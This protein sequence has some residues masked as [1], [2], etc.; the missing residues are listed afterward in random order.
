MFKKILVASAVV[1][2]AAVIGGGVYYSRS[3]AINQ[4]NKTPIVDTKNWKTY[5]SKYGFV[6]KYPGKWNLKED[7]YGLFLGMGHGKVS[8]D[9]YNG[10][11]SISFGYYSIED[12]GDKEIVGYVEQNN[13]S[14][15]AR[16]LAEKANVISKIE[17]TDVVE[18]IGGKAYLFYGDSQQNPEKK[19]ILAHVYSLKSKTFLIVQQELSV[20]IDIFESVIK[21]VSI[22]K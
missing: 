10:Q 16:K 6:I 14:T 22:I 21:K 4:K 2:V 8:F 12:S 18:I 13:I 17:I 1:A 9:I 3:I 5:V 20:N 15:A 11:Y 7:E 19:T